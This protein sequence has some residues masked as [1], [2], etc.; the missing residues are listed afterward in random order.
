MT[1]A[2]PPT[3]YG[4]H[5]RVDPLYASGPHE[6]VERAYL[7]CHA[8][9]V[10]ALDGRVIDGVPLCQSSYGQYVDISLPAARERRDFYGDEL[11]S[12]RLRWVEIDSIRPLPQS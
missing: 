2:T 4:T 12:V 10:V 5:I 1:V 3:E 6:A 11:P 8:L 9:R 7:G